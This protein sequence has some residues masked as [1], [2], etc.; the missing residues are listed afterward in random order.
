LSKA[1]ILSVLVLTLTISCASVQTDIRFE[2]I[3]LEESKLPEF[4]REL[5][6]LRAEPNQTAVIEIRARLAEFAATGTSDP[7][8]IARLKA[9]QAE[10]ALL[11]GERNPAQR[12]VNE[13]L[14]RNPGDEYALLVY[15]RLL[16]DN[17]IAL[18]Y[19]EKAVT[20]A[21]S[22]SILD[23]ERGLRLES[24]GKYP[25]AVAALDS[26]L[27]R[28][29]EA[30]RKLYLP[31]R[32]RAF[33]LRSLDSAPEKKTAEALTRN[34]AT[35]LDALVLLRN[36]S[37]LLDWYLGETR[38]RDIDVL[39]RFAA[40]NWIPPENR[41]AKGVLDRA[42]AAML[43]WR[44]LCA[45][46]SVRLTR[47]STRYKT[48]GKLPFSDVSLDDPWFDSAVGMVEAEIFLMAGPSLFS[49]RLPVSGKDF[50]EM[51]RRAEA[52]K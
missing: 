6:L 49:P 24:S 18:E 13:A 2:Q 23:A 37:T 34:P 5:A 35:L 11:A 51:I 44:A 1:F 7:R 39:N 45:Q 20:T 12:L 48:R 15:S 36:E 30:Q 27:P 17:Q 19:L 38:A 9:L 8:F 47:Y 50:F 25:E 42:T 40:E 14:A 46:D 16:G 10:A 26:A 4:T 3:L 41:N 33:S 31:I 21:D 29:D 28:L 32:D 43:L 22:R 52:V